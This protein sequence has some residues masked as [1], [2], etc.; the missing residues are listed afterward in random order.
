MRSWKRL[1]VCTASAFAL[2]GCGGSSGVPVGGPRADSGF[3]DVDSGRRPGLGLDSGAATEAAALADSATTQSADSGSDQGTVSIYCDQ[4]A[5]LPMGGLC[6]IDEDVPAAQAAGWRT[7][8]GGTVAESCPGGSV[9][10]CT[11]SQPGLT[12][13]E[14]WYPPMTT[15]DIQS[16]CPQMNGTFSST[17][18]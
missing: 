16:E 3:G 8:C 2:G 17:P 11:F 12:I 5:T 13:Q 15:A 14:C 6:T 18:F 4:T 7:A 10:C 1:V 9:G